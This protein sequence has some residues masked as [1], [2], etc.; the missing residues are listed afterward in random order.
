[1]NGN[2]SY[3]MISLE[4][5]NDESDDI[6]FKDWCIKLIKGS[7]PTIMG[8]LFETLVEII[9]LVFI[10]SLN[11]PIMIAGIGLG[12]LIVNV[13]A[14][15]ITTGLWGGIDT[16][17]SQNHGKKQ[18]YECGV[19][20]NKCRVILIAT[21]VFQAWL[22][23]HSEKILIL[24]GQDPLVASAAQ[25]YITFL[26]PGIF[27]FN[28]FEC[29][30]RFLNA[31][32]IFYEP[33]VTQSITVLLHFVWWYYFVVVSDMGLIGASFAT[34][35]TYFLDYVILY[36]QIMVKT[37]LLQK[38]SYHWINQDSLR[39]LPQFLDKAIPWVIIWCL[40]WWCFE[41]LSIIAGW[42]S[43]IELA[44]NVNLLNL[45]YIIYNFPLGMS[46]TACALV[47]NALGE[48]R[49]RIAVKYCQ[50]S[51]IL[52]FHFWILTILIL[53]IFNNSIAQMFTSQTEIVK[54]MHKL[55]PIYA[56]I[57]IWDYIQGVQ[58][59]IIRGMGYQRYASAVITVAYWWG[60]IPIAYLL[61][62]K[63]DY[64][65]I[66]VWMGIPTG[67]LIIWSWFSYVL[68]TTNWKKLST[69][70]RSHIEN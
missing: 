29:L 3:Q 60:A 57:V 70:I 20:F 63:L 16:L 43:E 55:I 39:N 21:F 4:I 42:L 56:L 33:S 30:R 8:L 2:E 65:L 31:Q 37:D 44:A 11:D 41:F 32:L 40:E 27:W 19:N 58:G 48:G 54:L 45:N 50:T 15:S 38:D 68:L 13:V 61:A 14:L 47:G 52:A 9:N 62:I 1:M 17:V 64:R 5:E 59:G 18:F 67:S 7:I 6:N 53:L 69:Q 10:G 22:L 35:I 24:L 28:M 23:L 34:W 26:I 36:V 46:Y 51:M 25:L 66:G 49:P 12:T